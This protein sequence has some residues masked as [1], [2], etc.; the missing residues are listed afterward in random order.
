VQHSN[1]TRTTKLAVLASRRSGIDRLSLHGELDR[2]NIGRLE[3]E[4]LGVVHPDGAIVLH[5]RDLVSIDTWGLSL[6]ERAMRLARSGAWQLTIITDDGAVRDAFEDGGIGHLLSGPH[7]SDLL[8]AGDGEWSPV[9]VS[10]FLGQRAGA[11][12]LAVETS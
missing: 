8:D 4:L 10:P 11:Q 5:L 9:A 12:P 7:L 3:R 6:M 1:G 2:S